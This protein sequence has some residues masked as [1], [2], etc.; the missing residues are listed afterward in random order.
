[1]KLPPSLFSSALSVCLCV[2]QSRSVNS[3]FILLF[4]CNTNL[5]FFI[6]SSTCFF[7]RNART[8]ESSIRVNGWS[9]QRISHLQ[10]EALED[11]ASGWTN[12]EGGRRERLEK[13]DECLLV[14][15]QFFHLL[16]RGSR[17][18]CVCVC[19]C[20]GMGVWRWNGA[21]GRAKL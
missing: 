6:R 18:V 12:I 7:L 21:R 17:C 14:G 3:F 4:P 13:M 20:A 11:N 2:F 19:F 1:M 10:V 16:R 9:R 5:S 15:E 8:N